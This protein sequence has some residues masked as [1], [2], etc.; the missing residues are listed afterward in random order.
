[1]RE[2]PSLRKLAPAEANALFDL[3]QG[4]TGEAFA[5]ANN[6]WDTET[7]GTYVVF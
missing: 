4:P 5:N 7:P 6:G 2:T 1:M 3:L